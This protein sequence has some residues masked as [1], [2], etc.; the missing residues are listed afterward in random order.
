MD[1]KRFLIECWARFLKPFLIL[2]FLVFFVF[3]FT[4]LSQIGEGLSLLFLI[5]FIIAIISVLFQLIICS[6]KN[7]LPEKFVKSVDT[8]YQKLILV[9]PVLITIFLIVEWVNK[10]PLEK[11]I[12]I[13]LLAILIYDTYFKRK[14]LRNDKI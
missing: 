10:S 11:I 12:L 4:Q 5:F 2:V 14:H 6:I 7:S 8:I 9:S 3:N 1:R 13:L